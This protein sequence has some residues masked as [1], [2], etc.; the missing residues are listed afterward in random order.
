MKPVNSC[1]KVLFF[2]GYSVLIEGHTSLSIGVVS[3][4][5]KGVGA[6][7]KKG[8][9][10]IVS[11]Q[12]GIDEEPEEAFEKGIMVAYAYITAKTYLSE[13]NKWEKTEVKL[14]N[15]E[16]MG[17]KDEKSG[18]GSSA[19]S[20][21]STIKALFRANGYCINAHIETIHK[22]SQF[23]YA[24]YSKK[25]GSGFDIATSS[26]NKSIIYSRYSENEIVIPESKEEIRKALMKTIEKP[27]KGIKIKPIQ[28]ERKGLDVLFFNIKNAKRESISAVNAF[29][30]WKKKNQEEFKKLT[31]MQNAFEKAA[32]H[33][34]KHQEYEKLRALTH[35]AREIHKKMQNS[36]KKAVGEF[37]EIEPEEIT[38]IIDE[39]EEI[40]GVVAGRDP[41]AGGMDGIAFLVKKEADKKEIAEKI[42]EIAEKNGVKMK[43]LEVRAL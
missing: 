16:I 9:E 3:R 29:K 14:K 19:A 30:L 33:S 10:R 25:T 2:G 5:G 1:G 37:E 6:E 7:F 21:T 27:W 24:F 40:E 39:S 17:K 43:Y 18:L 20:I 42:T 11:P 4:E 13:F 31:T 28:M 22:L 23:A 36:I 34:L 32:I 35:K 12:F 26:F 8:E 15:D 41:G 38:R